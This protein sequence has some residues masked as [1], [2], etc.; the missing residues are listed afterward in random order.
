MGLSRHVQSAQSQPHRDLASSLCK[1]LQ[2]LYRR[3]IGTPT[4][5]I[6]ETVDS[7][8][9]C[10]ARPRVLDS[11]CGTG[12]SV[13]RL[14]ERY[15]EAWV[16]GVDRSAH[17][18]RSD[19]WDQ[20]YRREGR[21]LWVRADLVDFW[22]LARQAGWRLDAHWLLYPNPWPKIGHLQR[23]WHGHPVFPTLLVL[24]GVLEVR[25]NWRVYAEELT[26][27]LDWS[28]GI[29]VEVENVPDEPPLT[30]FERKYAASGHPLYR[31]RANLGG[32]TRGLP[33]CTTRSFIQ[34][35]AAVD[36][37]RKKWTNPGP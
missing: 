12:V 16:V 20:G 2:N 32:A 13:R 26:L 31:V 33:E 37:A 27:A 29:P 4:A 18:L 25:T 15:P 22:R 19:T 11:G 28:A 35:S 8:L 3:P 30:P 1:H 17:R 14:A 36:A 6:F 24:G 23:R 21:C 5:R 7:L 34:R 10:E 9:R